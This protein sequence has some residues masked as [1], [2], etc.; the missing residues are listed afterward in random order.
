MF[1]SCLTLGECLTIMTV[2]RTPSAKE[3]NDFRPVALTSII[4]KCMGR[5]VCNQLI[6]YVDDHM[7]MDSL[8]FAY[9]ARRGVRML[10]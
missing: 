3:M 7:H 2:P 8:Q 4:V 10:P 5:I 1:I 6:T 9:G